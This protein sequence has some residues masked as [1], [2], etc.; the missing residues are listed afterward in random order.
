MGNLVGALLHG[1]EGGAAMTR[2]QT[3][4]I[5][6]VN[7]AISLV[8]SLSVSL[9]MVYIFLLSLEVVQV[10][11][12]P[13]MPAQTGGTTLPP[14]AVAIIPSPKPTTTTYI[15]QPGDSLSGI[16]FHGHSCRPCTGFDSIYSWYG[17]YFR[18]H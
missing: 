5:I 4:F 14:Q 9:I 1:V 12:G 7:A 3:V 13:G 2:K 10:P 16:A 8:I 18:L 17:K 11:V 15:V 6:V